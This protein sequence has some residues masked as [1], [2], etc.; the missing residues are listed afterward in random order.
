VIG[1]PEGEQKAAVDRPAV[2]SARIVQC[3]SKRR[4]SPQTARLAGGRRSGQPGGKQGGERA[5]G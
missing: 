5:S 3:G 4:L 1:T 2:G